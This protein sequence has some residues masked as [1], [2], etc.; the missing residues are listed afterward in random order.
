MC[1]DI[2]DDNKYTE[3]D[4]V[5]KTSQP[6]EVLKAESSDIVYFSHRDF[7]DNYAIPGLSSF[8]N[9]L[10]TN[11]RQKNLNFS[12]ASREGSLIK[13]VSLINNMLLEVE[14]NPFDTIDEKYLIKVLERKQNDPLILL[15]RMLESPLKKPTS[16]KKETFK[17]TSLI[18]AIIKDSPI[19]FF[20]DPEYNLS[21][22]ALALLKNAIFVEAKKNQKSI[23]IKTD[24]IQYWQNIVDKILIK[25]EMNKYHIYELE[26]SAT[27][28]N[29]ELERKS[30]LKKA[31]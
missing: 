6:V 22:K 23:F 27:N 9:Y 25:N 17:L 13:T 28:E 2:K 30:I 21:E 29:N 12:Y 24:K 31:S 15:Y 3:K 26:N 11:Y 4:S 16:I 1:L 5:N 7:L 19:I 8:V 20:E 10:N 18:R 14:T